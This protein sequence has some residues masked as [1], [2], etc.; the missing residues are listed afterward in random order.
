MPVAA[1]RWQLNIVISDLY[2]KQVSGHYSGKVAFTHLHQLPTVAAPVCR[3]LTDRHT[4]T[5]VEQC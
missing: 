2:N 1:I 5:P 4:A 3:Y